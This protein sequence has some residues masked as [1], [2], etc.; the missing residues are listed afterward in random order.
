M[1]ELLSIGK[2]L[3]VVV[4][5]RVVGLNEAGNEGMYLNQ[6]QG[7]MNIG[8]KTVLLLGDDES[9]LKLAMNPTFLTTLKAHSD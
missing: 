7:E 3:T 6:L 9:S 5:V 8:N 2:S 1:Q 4:R